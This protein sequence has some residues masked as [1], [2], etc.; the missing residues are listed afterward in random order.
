MWPTLVHILRRLTRW[1]FVGA[2]IATGWIF[3]VLQSWVAAVTAPPKEVLIWAIPTI[4]AF[5]YLIFV[6]LLAAIVKLVTLA[7]GRGSAAFQASAIKYARQLDREGADRALL[8]LRRGV[9]MLL[10]T[11]NANDTRV[12]LGELALDAAVRL[13]DRGEQLR[14]LIDDLGW[15]SHMAGHSQV[16]L[17]HINLALSMLAVGEDSSLERSLLKIKALRHRGIIISHWDLVKGLAVLDESA[18]EVDRLAPGRVKSVQ[19]A[20]IYHAKALAATEVLGLMD[21]AQIDYADDEA[22]LRAEEA[23]VSVREAITRFGDAKSASRLA[24]ARHLETQL[25]CALRRDTEVRMAKV[26]EQK[27]L[28]QSAWRDGTHNL[29][30]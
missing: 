19:E 13:G 17:R 24:K 29:R 6:L 5:G 12:E 28:D 23:L 16:A 21:G 20:Q 3:Q 7:G 4:G 18:A 15:A 8:E 30:G 1:L 25:L 14:I 26:L 11:Q 2:I 22:K 27:S 9:S 10:H